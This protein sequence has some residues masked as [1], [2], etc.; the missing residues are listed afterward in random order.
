MSAQA[1]RSV[2]IAIDR[3]AGEGGGEAAPATAGDRL[4]TEVHGRRA[5][6]A[7]EQ[8]SAQAGQR[9][10]AGTETGVEVGAEGTKVGQ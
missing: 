4:E 1:P 6:P 8:G 10:P 2:H 7:R 5:W 3:A 9:V